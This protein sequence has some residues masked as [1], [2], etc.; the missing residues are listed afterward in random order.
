MCGFLIPKIKEPKAARQ[1]F[2]QGTLKFPICRHR[3]AEVSRLRTH[4]PKCV[5]K[6]GNSTIDE[7][8]HHL[9]LPQGSA[10]HRLITFLHPQPV[11]E[12]KAVCSMI[13]PTTQI[14]GS[15]TTMPR[16]LS[17]NKC[18]CARLVPMVLLIQAAW[19]LGT[20]NRKI[21]SRCDTL[22]VVEIPGTLGALFLAWFRG[23][24]SHFKDPSQEACP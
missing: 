21:L 14:L 11:R 16:T 4:F 10:V 2:V 15:V 9:F 19:G 1:G 6:H 17:G 5:A 18:H 23:G 20:F 3:S 8:K 13:T 7:G 12:P 24:L 22:G